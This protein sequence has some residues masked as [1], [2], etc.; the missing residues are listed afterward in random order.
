MSNKNNEPSVAGLLLVTVA[1]L[2]L[3]YWT[4]PNYF[5]H[6]NYRTSK[7][8][9]SA[10]DSTHLTWEY[11]N[12]FDGQTYAFQRMLSSSDYQKIRASHTLTALYPS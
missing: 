10:L 9:V 3:I 7:A 2:G 6:L 8:T 11:N 12:T 4:L 1:A 5:L